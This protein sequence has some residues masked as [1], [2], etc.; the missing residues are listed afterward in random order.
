MVREVYPNSDGNTIP[1]V[2]AC[3]MI[4]AISGQLMFGYIGDAL[5]R[6]KV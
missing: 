1:V 5:G 3:S 4:G 6:R 2:S